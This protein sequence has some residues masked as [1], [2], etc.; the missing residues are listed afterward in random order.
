MR[1]SLSAGSMFPY[2]KW[3]R[4]CQVDSHDHTA[5][6][7]LPNEAHRNI[8]LLDRHPCEKDE[9]D[10]RSKTKPLKL[11]LINSI[12]IFNQL[13]KLFVSLSFEH[14][15]EKHI[16]CCRIR[17]TRKGF[18]LKESSKC[19]IRSKLPM[20]DWDSLMNG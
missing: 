11:L 12:N 13:L 1:Q 3:R 7:I 8:D 9:G 4:I 19:D 5:E 17:N 20:A 18:S 15:Y 6:Y 16:L 14:I 2:Q 10:Y